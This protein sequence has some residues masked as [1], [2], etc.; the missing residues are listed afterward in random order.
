[1]KQASLITHSIVVAVILRSPQ[2]VVQH[3]IQLK[4][5]I[6]DEDDMSTP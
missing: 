1:M 5:K 2:W 4:N 6:Q 3:H